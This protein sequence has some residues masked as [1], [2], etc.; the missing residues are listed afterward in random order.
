MR[1]AREE[2][3]RNGGRIRLLVVENEVSTIFALRSFF[4]LGGFE[5]DCALGRYDGLQLL[6]RRAYD[7]VLTDLQLTPERSSEGFDIAEHARER[8]PRACIVLLTA[9]GS[10]G[11]EQRAA[12]CGVDL[13]F[14]K[15][16]SL[17]HL[18]DFVCRHRR[19]AGT[20]D[21]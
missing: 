6:E 15:P 8:N 17:P 11:T 10:E 3:K 13:Y 20:P 12:R 14:T 4:A 16:V 21:G 2:L 5:V 19:Y 1:D 9:Y 7:A 18:L